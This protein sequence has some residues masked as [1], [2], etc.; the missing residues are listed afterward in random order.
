[1]A[2]LA[3]KST[4]PQKNVSLSK[5]QKGH[6]YS[7]CLQYESWSKN[8]KH[9]LVPPQ[10]G[11]CVSGHSKF[12]PFCACLQ[13]CTIAES[14]D[15]GITNKFQQV[16]KFANR[17]PINNKGQ[18]YS[19]SPSPAGKGIYNPS[20]RNCRYYMHLCTCLKSCCSPAVSNQCMP[21]EQVINAVIKFA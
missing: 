13:M 4:K 7:H 6:L 8:T 12:S 14:F 10:L 11:T 1:M 16:G 21:Y 18:L 20:R 3:T 15:L 9:C 5:L 19:L 2:K 17:G